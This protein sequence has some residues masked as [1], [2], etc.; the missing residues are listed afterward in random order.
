MKTAAECSWDQVRDGTLLRAAEDS[1]FDVLLTGDKTMH[2]EQN[3]L[4]LRMG[5][6]S[7]S[8]NHWKIIRDYTASIVDAI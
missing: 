1:G 2:H 7:M 8:D 4:S 3:M 5:I 6:V